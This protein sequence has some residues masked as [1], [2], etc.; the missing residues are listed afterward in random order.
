MSASRKVLI[1]GGIALAIWGMSYG[2]WYALFDEHQ[3]LERMG[4]SLAEGF[5]HA[6][7]RNLSGM[8]ASINQFAATKFEYVREV[9]VH[10]HWIGLAMLLII[11][12][13]VFERV[14]FSERTR[15]LLAWTLLA[16]SVVFP[17]GVIL[18]T[19]DRG[20]G[21]QALAAAGSVAV[22][23]ALAAVALGFWRA[24]PAA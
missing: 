1:V 21:P 11:L 4:M 23:I 20:I 19:F 14:A 7:D 22:T 17:L 3:T 18:Q 15:V 12:G 2:L 9:D 6:A 24:K 13:V 16:G 10:S 8:D 5:A